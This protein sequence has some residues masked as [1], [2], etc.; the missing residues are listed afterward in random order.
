M[1]AQG[2]A[3]RLGE[4]PPRGFRL[5]LTRCLL[6]YFAQTGCPTSRLRRCKV[7][8]V[9]PCDSPEDDGLTGGVVARTRTVQGRPNPAQ[10]AMAR[11]HLTNLEKPRTCAKNQ[12]FCGGP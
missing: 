6:L 5:R 12:F 11:P 10:G 4:C 9:R 8:A 3:A 1:P 7:R 2:G